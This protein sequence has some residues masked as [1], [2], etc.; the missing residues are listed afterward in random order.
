MKGVETFIALKRHYIRKTIKFAN[1]KTQVT[2]TCV[3]L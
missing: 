2:L 3:H 1:R